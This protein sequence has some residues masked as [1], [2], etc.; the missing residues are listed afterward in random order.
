MNQTLAYQRL[1]QLTEQFIPIMKGELD[2]VGAPDIQSETNQDFQQQGLQ[3]NRPKIIAGKAETDAHFQAI[4]Q[5]WEATHPE[6]G[7]PYWLTRS[8]LMSI[9][10]PVYLAVFSVYLLKAVPNLQNMT[11]HYAE[12]VVAGYRLAPE[13][14]TEGNDRQLIQ[15]ACAH[16]ITLVNQFQHH[17]N[18]FTR[19]RPGMTRPLLADNILEA[20]ATLA[21]H[22]P[23]T[24]PDDLKNHA[25]LW[26]TELALASRHLDSLSQIAPQQHDNSPCWQ[27]ARIS[28]CMHYRRHD[29]KLCAN[30]PRAA[31]R[32][33]QDT[34][35]NNR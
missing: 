7:H 25:R 22:F 17:F 9:W 4:Y 33:K 15:T 23:D 16:L 35:R 29:G 1:F 27:V 30:C 13:G 24:A 28:C 21:N 14:I 32:S 6:A 19:L 18:V 20:L 8:W 2:V 11:Q 10:Q 12:G 34:G 26:L 5:F 31:K 3:K